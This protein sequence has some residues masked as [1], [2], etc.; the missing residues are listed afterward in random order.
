MSYNIVYGKDKRR[1]PGPKSPWKKP[2]IYALIALTLIVTA[3]VT[4]LSAAIW[5]FLLPGDPTVTEAALIG[6]VENIKNGVSLS[7]TVTAFCQEI[8]HGANLS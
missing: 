3:H 4:G 8:I 7:D 2:L 6:M 5:R 1:Y